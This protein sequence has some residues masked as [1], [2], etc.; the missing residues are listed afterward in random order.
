MQLQPRPIVGANNYRNIRNFELTLMFPALRSSALRRHSALFNT[1]RGPISRRWVHQEESTPKSGYKAR[2]DSWLNPTI[3]VLGFIPILTFTLGTWQLQRL[4]WKVNL[5]DEL[6]EKLEREPI[7]L[8]R[9][10]K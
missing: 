10:V 1:C 7:T 4:Q 8:P 9:Q 5:I 3:L 6:K 2:R